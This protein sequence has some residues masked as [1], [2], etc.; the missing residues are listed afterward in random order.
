[1][2]VCVCVCV[3]VLGRRKANKNERPPHPPH[4]PPKKEGGKK[5][6]FLQLAL[7]TDMI[8]EHCWKKNVRKDLHNMK[9]SLVCS[10]Q[11]ILLFIIH[12]VE[13]NQVPVRHSYEEGQ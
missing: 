7:D 1:M 3:C 10:Q 11:Y 5:L 6:V 8:I 9:K 2:C 4:P 13:T 12:T